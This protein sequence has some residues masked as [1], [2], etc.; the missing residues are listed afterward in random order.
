MLA[1]VARI[2]KGDPERRLV[3]RMAGSVAAINAFED[4]AR[5]RTAAE[6][7]VRTAALK[8]QFA[9]GKSLDDLLPEAFAL[10]REAARRVLGQRH[11]DVQLMGGMVLHDGKV[12]EM[13]TGEGKTLVAV[14]PAYLNALSGWPVH[15][16]TVNDYLALRDSQ[17]MGR[18]FAFLGLTVGCVLPGM[19]DPDRRTAYSADVTYVTNAEVGFDYLRDNMK[20]SRGEMVHRP[21]SFAIIDEVDSIL[22]DEARTPL[23]ITG[24]GPDASVPVSVADSAVARLSTSDCDIDIK[25]RTINL[26]DGGLVRLEGILVEMGAITADGHLHDHDNLALVPFVHASLRARHLFHPERDYI[27]RDGKVHIVDQGTGRVL[28]GRRYSDGLHQALEAREGVDILPENITAAS[29]TYQNFFR[30]YSKLSGMTGTARTEADEFAEI[31]GLDVVSVPTNVPVI[32]LDADDDVYLA[33]VDRDAAVVSIVKAA[34]RKGQPVLVGTSSIERSEALSELFWAS[35]IP[36]AVLNARQHEHE[37][38]IVAQAGRLGSVTIATNMAGRGT[39]IKLGGN[40]KMMLTDALPLDCEDAEREALEGIIAAQVAEEAAAVRL[41]GGL[42]VVGTQRHESRRVDD[43]LRGRSGRQGDPGESRFL[44]SLDDDLMKRFGGD[45]MGGMMARM[46]MEPGEPVTHPWVTGSV[47]RAQQKIEAQ[48]F[49][50]RKNLLKYDDVANLQRKVFYR[51]RMWVIDGQEGPDVGDAVGGMI[52]SAVEQMVAQAMPKEAFAEQWDGV[53]LVGAVAGLLNLAL[54]IPAWLSEDGMNVAEMGRR[55]LSA[56]T[57]REAV[58]VAAISREAFDSVR[59]QILLQSMD[60]GWNEHL[61]ELDALRDG[62]HL[63]AYA[64]KNPLYEWHREADRLF[65][66]MFDK[67]GERTIQGISRLT[68]LQGDPE[69]IAGTSQ[70]SAIEEQANITDGDIHVV[71]GDWTDVTSTRRRLAD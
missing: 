29:V 65:K 18:V 19:S 3:R 17:E 2:F 69:D 15:I 28:E 32:R 16:V 31:Y 5:G 48:N 50:G 63:R 61:S 52:G 49:E 6:F 40:A 66:G 30:L 39:D 4:S 60:I 36:H 53:G 22:I 64:Q 59:R 21:L 25:Q 42:L 20:T 45:R 67:A 11:Y 33:T 41:V 47:R 12:A 8:A 43:Q 27:V 10:A 14:L 58:I 62:I 1:A 26:T 71:D 68:V 38:R 57:E 37:A 35:A 7:L 23:V 46:G 70:N 24:M 9:S 13:R 51:K 56:V 54:P 55:I 44:I 34:Q